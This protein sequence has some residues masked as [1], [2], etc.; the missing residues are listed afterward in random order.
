[1]IVPNIISNPKII[2][3]V[4]QLTKEMERQGVKEY[5]LWPSIQIAN[6]PRRTGISRAHKQIVEWALNEGLEDVCIMEDDVWFPASD[7]WQYFLDNKPKT[8]YDLYLGGIY[9]GEIKEGKVHRYTGQICY[10]IHEKF[11]TTFLGVDEMLDIDGAM[12]GLGD[13]HVCYPFAAICYPG[14]SENTSGMMDYTHLLTGR[15]I[16]GFG[17]VKNKEDVKN[18]SA[19]SKTM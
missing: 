17:V 13:F 18:L 7:G 16:R 12:S 4:N 1:M 5:K 3:R 14:Y 8:P 11:Y 19:L 15:D 6:K 9:R 2:S 10:F